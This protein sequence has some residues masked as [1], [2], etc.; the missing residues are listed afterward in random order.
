MIKDLF[1]LREGEIFNTL[2]E[3]R[4][5]DFSIIGGYA[6]NAYTLPRFSVDCDIVIK[7]E[8]VLRKIEKILLKVGYKKEKLPQEAQYSGNFS[9]YEKKLSNNFAVSMD[10]LISHVTDRMTGVVF[11][12]DWI[13]ENSSM[14]LLRGKT[15]TEELK[16]RILHIDAL[17][18]MKMISCRSTDIRDVFMM[19]PNAKDK[20]WIKSEISLRYYFK[21]RITKIIE[22]ISSK[23]FKDG[24]SGVYGYFDQNVFEKHKK[25]IIGFISL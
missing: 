10:I 18:V 21:D 22:K 11:A 1:S 9:R 4:D 8:T 13:F 23:Q 12:A 14:Q 16:M 25:A 20:E 7:D 19:F 2:K 24:L 3:L 15:I 17:L 6:V 5:C